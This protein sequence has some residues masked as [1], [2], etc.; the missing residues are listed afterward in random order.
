MEQHATTNNIHPTFDVKLGQVTFNFHPQAPNNVILDCETTPQPPEIFDNVKFKTSVNKT[1]KYYKSLT[2]VTKN[3]ANKLRKLTNPKT[4]NNTDEMYIVFLRELK[5][6]K[7]RSIRRV[8]RKRFKSTN[9]RYVYLPHGIQFSDTNTMRLPEEVKLRMEK[10][11][12]LMKKH[13]AA[14]GMLFLEFAFNMTESSIYEDLNF[15]SLIRSNF[16]NVPHTIELIRDG[17]ACNWKFTKSA[18]YLMNVFENANSIH[19]AYNKADSTVRIDVME[20]LFYGISDHPRERYGASLIRCLPFFEGPGMQDLKAKV[21]AVSTV[22]W[23][24]DIKIVCTDWI[25]NSLSVQAINSV[26]RA[27]YLFSFH[28]D[29]KLLLDSLCGEFEKSIKELCDLQIK[30]DK[31]FN[32]A[33]IK[34]S[35]I[36]YSYPLEKHVQLPDMALIEDNFPSKEYHKQFETYYEFVYAMYAK[37]YHCLDYD[38][39]SYQ[40][41]GIPP[42]CIT[43]QDK[44]K[45]EEHCKAIQCE[46]ANAFKKFRDSLA[47]VFTNSKDKGKGPPKYLEIQFYHTSNQLQTLCRPTSPCSSTKPNSPTATLKCSLPFLVS[48]NCTQP[49]HCAYAHNILSSKFHSSVYT[50]YELEAERRKLSKEKKAESIAGTESIIHQIRHQKYSRIRN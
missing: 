12:T 29:P 9:V 1:I 21:M 5:D 2:H 39:K 20:Q 40:Y 19:A 34:G 16:K 36:N 23:L 17:A 42:H 10:L 44:I 15:Y 3:V 46:A 4:L 49:S 18:D 47:F 8:Y 33:Q 6:G 45:I 30:R 50:L 31:Y 24:R 11:R 32:L 7:R 13:G 27:K 28:K 48:E 37:G 22:C 26:N 41:H 25:S 14:M 43:S 35:F 38:A